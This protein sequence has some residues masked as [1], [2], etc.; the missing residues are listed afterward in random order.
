MC[1]TLKQSLCIRDLQDYIQDEI[2]LRTG[3]IFFSGQIFD[4]LSLNIYLICHGFMIS[5]VNFHVFIFLEF[6]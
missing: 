3:Q 4:D 5:G 2:N 1:F 6:Y